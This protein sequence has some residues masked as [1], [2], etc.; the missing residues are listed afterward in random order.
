VLE[1]V[2]TFCVEAGGSWR[3][4]NASDRNDKLR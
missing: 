3:P 2:A 1:N 4:K